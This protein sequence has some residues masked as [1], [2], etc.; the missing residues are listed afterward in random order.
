MRPSSQSILDLQACWTSKNMP[1][2]SKLQISQH[3][4]IAEMSHPVITEQPHPHKLRIQILNLET[5]LHL[6]DFVNVKCT[7]IP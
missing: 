6:K 4:I 1:P 3:R 2:L 7:A 5:V